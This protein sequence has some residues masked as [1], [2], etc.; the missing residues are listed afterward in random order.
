MDIKSLIDRPTA[1]ETASS[2]ATSS[3]VIESR[4][5]TVSSLLN[6]D[7]EAEA[8][9][10]AAERREEELRQEQHEE[11]QEQSERRPQ[12]E[13]PATPEKKKPEKE[14][15]KE[16]QRRRD[17]PRRYKT[18]PIWAQSWKQFSRRFGAS[19]NVVAQPSAVAV[20]D[21]DGSGGAG[22]VGGERL[23]ST[24]TGVVPFE[25]LSRK[26]TEWLYGNLDQLETDARQHVEVELKL[27]TICDKATE[28]RLQMPVVTETILRSDYARADTFFQA[29]MSDAQFNNANGFLDE[30]AGKRPPTVTR[31]LS[32]TRDS[33]YAARGP[34]KTRV[35]FN[36][37]TGATERVIK[38][39]IADLMIFSPGDLLDIRISISTE[40]PAQPSA[41]ENG[42]PATVRHKNRQ[43]YVH[44]TGQVDLTSVVTGSANRATKEL[45]VELDAAQLVCFF[46]AYKSGADPQ[47]MDKFEDFIRS[48]VDNTR[49]IARRISR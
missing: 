28:K 32:K 35:T 45:E 1:E 18:P 37:G 22:G 25:D 43:T 26:V 47:A 34:G 38:T 5:H 2:S 6:D 17:K 23:F 7:G 3:P 42:N 15:D 19:R 4:R 16:K 31:Q 48:G 40:T 21:A 10:A 49:I 29:C 20:A 11:E 8:I 36:E 30:L 13:E 46:D 12:Q 44:S 33:I 41:A 24:I 14:E 27:G 9:K 39:R